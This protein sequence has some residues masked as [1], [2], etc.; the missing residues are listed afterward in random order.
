MEI[1]IDTDAYDTL[2]QAVNEFREV[3]VENGIILR[4][5]ANVCDQAMGS[6]AI[7]QKHIT[8]LNDALSELEKTAQIA[9]NIAAELKAE[10]VHALDIY[11]RA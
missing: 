10:K 1:Y 11:D 7:I 4:N 9:S 5:A 6:D 8:R 2:I 3:L